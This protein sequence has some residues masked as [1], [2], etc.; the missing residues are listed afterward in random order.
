MAKAEALYRLQ[1]LDSQLDAA[2]KRIR[3]I[4]AALAA[5][6]AVTHAQSE[7]AIAEKAARSTAGELKSLEL[8]AQTLDEKIRGE[9][10]RL[11]GGK[12]KV[13]KEML[14]TQKELDSLKK[15][16]GTLDDDLLAAMEKAEDARTTEANVRR[17]L[18][19][20]NQRWE[21]DNQHHRQE[22]A[23]LAAKATALKEQRTAASAAIPRADLDIYVALR[24][25]KPNGVA[26]ALIKTGSCSQCGETPS[27][28]QLQQARVGTTLTTCIACGRILYSA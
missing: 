26:V 2:Y 23:D 25:K 21:D 19:E 11:Y 22:R 24:A 1:N 14:D 13:A 18:A 16:R 10:E 3:E 8:D 17:A 6:S 28:M 4:D 27:S 12:I 5:N 20:A 15:R 7:L 9:E